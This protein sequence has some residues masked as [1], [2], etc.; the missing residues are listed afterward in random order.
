MTDI[1]NNPI[2]TDETAA[3]AYLERLRWPGGILCVHCGAYGQD[4]APVQNTG[5]RT[6]P[7]VPGKR[8]RPARE[9]IYYCNACKAQFSV[10]VGTIMEDSHLPL[11]KWLLAF[12]LMCSSKKGIS[13]HQLH[14]TLGIA[15]KT[16]W[17]L[18]HRI[19]ECMRS[20]FFAPPMGGSG[21]IT[22][23]DETFIG[24]QEG[25]KKGRSGYHHKMAVLTLI[26]R[27]GADTASGSAAVDDSSMLNYKYV[28]VQL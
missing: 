9:G 23:S 5:K 26:A 15:Y 11:H 14:R 25:Q 8:Y 20:G 18:S 7:A 27:L 12:R 3:R 13:S 4:I 19:R 17:H 22:E 10:T 21:R 24:R 16:A 6:R 28:S 2:Y 1:T